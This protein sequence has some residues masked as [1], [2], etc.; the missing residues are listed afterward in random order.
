MQTSIIRLDD[1]PEATNPFWHDVYNMGLYIG[2]NLTIMYNVHND[3]PAEY[4]IIIHKPTGRR[5][6]IMVDEY[7][8]GLSSE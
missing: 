2:D 7:F 4:I 3:E 6:K 1:I 5:I 8:N